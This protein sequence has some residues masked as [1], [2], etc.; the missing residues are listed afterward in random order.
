MLEDV[1]REARSA[2]REKRPFGIMGSSIAALWTMLELNC[3]V[4]FFV[5]EDPHRVSHELDGVPI[6]GPS[7]VPAGSLV[8]IP[9]SVPVAEKIIARWRHLAVEFRFVSTNRPL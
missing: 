8:F 4:D 9:M 2:A 6:F 1:R 5:D 7:Q 3:K